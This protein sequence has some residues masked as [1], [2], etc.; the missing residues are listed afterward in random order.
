MEVPFLFSSGGSTKNLQ[1]LGEIK[2]LV[3]NVF[4]TDPALLPPVMDVVNKKQCSR[5]LQC[6]VPCSVGNV[7]NSS[8]FN[9]S[10]LSSLFSTSHAV[11]GGE[12]EGAG[13]ISIHLATYC[14][15][16]WC[17]SLKGLRTFIVR[18][19]RRIGSGRQMREMTLTELD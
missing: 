7:I 16:T 13:D 2:L 18:I 15:T 1:I 19:V 12:G 10:S 6:E 17:F 3:N 8:L 11:R 5:Q 9:N 14:T 4:E